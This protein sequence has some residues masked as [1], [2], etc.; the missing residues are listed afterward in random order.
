MF[1][2]FEIR[3]LFTNNVLICLVFGVG[4]LAFARHHPK[5]SGIKHIGIATLLIGSSFF[6]LSLRHYVPN[7]SSIV[8]AN[9]LF[10][11][12]LMYM[13]RGLASFRGIKQERSVNLFHYTLF[14]IVCYTFWYLTFVDFDTNSRIIIISLATSAE[15]L[16]M[17]QVMRTNQIQQ[18]IPPNSFL[19]ATYFSF[20]WFFVMRALGTAFSDPL[21]DFMNAGIFH[22]IAAFNF[23]IIVLATSLVLGWMAATALEKELIE[24]ATHDPLT[25]LY[26][27]RAL[28]ELVEK[29]CSRAE[30]THEAFS[31]LMTDIDFFKKL[32]D[33]YGHQKGD[34][35]LKMFATIL[36][37]NTREHDIV[38][39]FG[40][41][42]FIIVLPETDIEP[43]R[44]LAEKL[45]STIEDCEIP[46]SDTTP[47]NMTASFGVTTCNNGESWDKI[48]KRVDHALYEAKGRGRNQVAY[49]K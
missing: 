31:V 44:A 49:E 12:A 16:L 36:E 3:T 45:R 39:R 20:A 46:T 30:R 43:A 40:G 18:R 27:R 32:N 13:E 34:E 10:I 35:V 28:S 6:L 14:V 26:N 15:L 24:E 1:G 17:A 42:E 2:I 41:E 19:A 4:L 47:L 21:D 25:K 8:I 5:F 29:E 38:A 23:Q 48:M 22:V 11:V 7:L 33:I 9:T 37:N